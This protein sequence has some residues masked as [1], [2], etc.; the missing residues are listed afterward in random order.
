[1]TDNDKWH[2][3]SYPGSSP[4]EP[5]YEASDMYKLVGCDYFSKLVCFVLPLHSCESCTVS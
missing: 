2:V 4:A 5:E 1:M 3:A